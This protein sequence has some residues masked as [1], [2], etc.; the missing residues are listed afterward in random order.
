MSNQRIARVLEWLVILVFW[1][2]RLRWE[3]LKIKVLLLSLS[4]MAGL[5]LIIGHKGVRIVRLTTAIIWMIGNLLPVEFQKK[6]YRLEDMKIWLREYLTSR[7]ALKYLS[8]VTK[9]RTNRNNSPLCGPQHPP[10]RRSSSQYPPKNP[11]SKKNPHLQMPAHR[12]SMT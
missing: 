4:V 9:T 7:F 10:E 12:K 5:K 2:T 3:W 11:R 8:S 6:P 1:L